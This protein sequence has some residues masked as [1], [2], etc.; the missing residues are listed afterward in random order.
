MI[1]DWRRLKTPAIY[2]SLVLLVVQGVLAA[3]TN[4]FAGQMAVNPNRSTLTWLAICLL[5]WAIGFT[6]SRTI[7]AAAVTKAE[8]Q[9][10]ADLLSAALAQPVS[11]LTSQPA[12]E[13][14][15]RV[16]DDTS[17]IG[18]FTRDILFMVIAF[19]CGLIPLWIVAAI[20][21]WPAWI[22]MP[23]LGVAV[24]FASRSKMALIA[25]RKVKEEEAW[26]A[27]ASAFEEAVSAR[28]DL[29]TS[30][31]QPFAIRR[32][33]ELSA[34]I[35]RRFKF[36]NRAAVQ[37]VLISGLLLQGALAAIVVTAV[38]LTSRGAMTISALVSLFLASVAIVGQ[39]GGLMHQIPQIQEGVGA[40]T[41]IKQLLSVKPEPLGGEPVP[42]GVIGIEITNLNFT[43]PD[44][45]NTVIASSTQNVITASTNNVIAG[46]T[47]NP[48]TENT[49]AIEDSPQNVITGPTNN[50]IADSTNNVIAGLTRNPASDK[51]S[52]FALQNINLTIPPG[53]T[54]ALVGRTGSGKSTVASMLS[55]AVEPPPGTIFLSGVMAD[56]NS[57]RP[58][59]PT[60]RQRV[61]ITALD[62]TALRQSVGVVTQR[63]EIL[64][65]TLRQNITIFADVP[66]GVVEN[67]IA[68]LGL[69][70]WVAG[71]ELGLDTPLGA[72]GT[73]LS[74]GEEQLIAF[75]RLLV[76]DVQVVVLDE[77]TA[78]MDPLTEALV[79]A[80]SSR[81]LTGRTGVLVAHRLSTIERADLVA[82][83]DHGQVS[84]FGPRA[85]LSQVAGPYQTL[86][87]AAQNGSLEVDDL[88]DDLLETP[89]SSA[90]AI[91]PPS[92]AALPIEGPNGD[93]PIA[94]GTIRR[95]G[96]MPGRRDPRKGYGLM[97]AVWRQFM[98]HKM[99]GLFG[100]LLF[101]LFAFGGAHGVVGSYFWGQI[102]AALESGGP[103]TALL[104]AFTV[105][106]L[107]SPL[108]LFT[109]EWLYPQWWIQQSLRVRMAVMRAQTSQRRL[110]ATPPGE[111]VA[112]AM[113]SDRIIEYADN[114]IDVLSGIVMAAVMVAMARSWIAGAVLLGIM[115]FSAAVA[116][117]GRP[118][119]GRSAKAAADARA[120][121][122]R[123]LVSA[124]DGIR[125]V[126]LSARTAQIQAH[127]R[128]V[129]ASR[130]KASVFEQTVSGV[131]HSVPMLLVNLAVLVSWW[132]FY[133]GTW[134][135]ATT[136]LVGSAAMGFQYIG[137]VAG[138]VITGFPGA[139]A[140]QVATSKFADGADLFALPPGVSTV[141]G[142][143]PPPPT[144]EQ[145][146]LGTLELVDV[147]VRHDDDGTIGAE[148]VSFKV[149][150]GEL[151]LLLGQVGSGKSSLLAALA[152]LM[153]H[154]GD[155]LWNGVKVTDPEG[156]LRP[157][158]V[159][160]V[161]QLP[162]V[163]S[164]T[165]VEN[166]ALDHA[167]RLIDQPIQD[168]RLIE[169][170]EVAGGVDALIGY[171]GVKLSGGQ[172][173]RLALARALATNSE[174]LLADD[175]SSALD[176]TTE[177][178]LWDALRAR[179]TTVIGS[180]SKAAALAKADRV[181][182]LIDGRVAATGPWEE[183]APQYAHL[184]G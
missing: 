95:H 15:D 85:E 26:T 12:G 172:A 24:Y 77:A 53:Q 9:L 134:D 123:T 10:R 71:L 129:D 56:S 132:L 179:G 65:G 143:A 44:A 35:H 20:T 110:P 131:L 153:W 57:G 62:L 163:I 69:T 171:R 176:A 40:I 151:V 34:E 115:V 2:L 101:T 173:Q 124:I 39:L 113:D 80:A 87:A 111:V 96:E 73:K 144:P 162:R 61:D 75:A 125:T 13:I 116:V 89:N 182:V 5:G 102:A 114:W 166:I 72:G 139:R 108:L 121:F 152:G 88:P 126:K 93:E 109:A 156:F 41:R 19:A 42:G 51:T 59:T 25:E 178:E 7:W 160:Y 8:G 31:G 79:V 67:A 167:D 138:L 81:L 105:T 91:K 11:V 168:A 140:W 21:W 169:D 155:V 46:L 137:V 154:D 33:A 82:V 70:D 36:M 107:V 27:H 84:Q 14:L 76:R 135:L 145:D 4:L 48:A 22:L 50:V 38:I 3:A 32:L 45:D 54:L 183:L 23:V 28:D 148:G 127:L 16:D 141:T 1:L 99:W 170:V 136:L 18:R 150:R 64:A 180:T 63:T 175:I 55:R 122:G 86:L 119:A 43:Y 17:A 118:I 120:K 149:E 146:R 161:G 164:G 133:L 174:V 78:R 181:V 158:R 106:L 142:V 147:T 60:P 165:F 66:A 58:T 159:A 128:K 100:A 29:R 90:V 98:N 177:L 97:Q 68:E 184:A 83:L 74:A 117:L 52:T 112:R 6:A 130:V 103:T 30:L 104:I 37:A 157:G 47:R 94:I 49:N 92:P